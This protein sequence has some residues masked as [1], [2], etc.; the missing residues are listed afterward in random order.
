MTLSDVF[1]LAAITVRQRQEDRFGR[2]RRWA[3]CAE[4]NF[5]PRSQGRGMAPP[6]GTDDGDRVELR[7]Y[8]GDSARFIHWGS[9]PGLAN[10][11]SGS[12]R[13]GV[14]KRTAAYLI[15]GSNDGASAAAA[16][17]A[18]ESTAFGPD[19]V[20]EW[21]ERRRMRTP[22]VPP[23]IAIDRSGSR[24]SSQNTGLS[25]FVRRAE[26]DGP[27]AIVVFAPSKSW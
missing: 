27:A 19:W 26:I 22:S 10:L 12:P 25:A 13:G 16:R 7:R 18:V 23:L 11:W 4:W 8:A 1:G 21:M 24:Y 20:S 2:L 9:S 5:Y 3:P 14:A 15:T 6:D 17:V